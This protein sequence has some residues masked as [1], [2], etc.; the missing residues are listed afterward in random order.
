MGAKSY[1]AYLLGETELYKCFRET[2]SFLVL[3]DESA[4]VVIDFPKSL[5]SYEWYVGVVRYCHAN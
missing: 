5:Q 4:N 2:P 1:I 3:L